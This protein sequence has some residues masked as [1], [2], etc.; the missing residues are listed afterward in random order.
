MSEYDVEMLISAD[1]EWLRDRFPP[2]VG[3]TLVNRTGLI[4]EI[5]LAELARCKAG[6]SLVEE[7]TL[8]EFWY[9]HI[10]SVLMRAEGIEAEREKWTR[11]AS[12]LLS[13]VI[14]D[15]A[16]NGVLRYSDIGIIDESRKTQKTS[17]FELCPYD[18]VIVFVEKDTLFKPLKNVCKL[19]NVP[20]VSGAGFTATAAIEG[21]IDALSSFNE[22][23]FDHK[24]TIL[25]ISDYDSYGFK[26]A[27]DFETRSLRLG[28]NCR[29]ERIGVNIE[30]F[31]QEMITTKRYP[32]S[33]KTT[34][35]KQWAATYGIE[36]RYGMELDA[37]VE[38]DGSKQKL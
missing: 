36:G 38:I 34:K 23:G 29:V 28:L 1:A 37:L 17:T 16:L 22:R 14:S 9:S 27:K 15:L 12:Q 32:V 13:A 3:N 21:V 2:K 10:K 33:Q 8:R 19:Y 24:Y 6:G 7:R 18:D 11:Q 35:D 25:V 30:H 4:R 26:I 5:V 31:D 20:F